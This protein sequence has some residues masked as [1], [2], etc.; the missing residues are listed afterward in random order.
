MTVDKPDLPGGG[1]AAGSEVR[2]EADSPDAVG[3]SVP[4]VGTES[5]SPIPASDAPRSSGGKHGSAS[6]RGWLHPA[7]SRSGRLLR[8]ALAALG[9]AVAF[10]VL[11]GL[12]IVVFAKSIGGTSSNDATPPPA[13]VIPTAAGSGTAGSA[14]PSDWVEQTSS[15]GVV[16]K[17]PPGWTPRSDGT[18]DFRVEPATSGP[19]INQVG[20]G[21]STATTDP[22]AAVRTYVTGTYS[23]QNS[24]L[25]Q[26]ATDQVS[27]RGERGRESTVSYSRSGTPVAVVVRGFPTPRG[28]LLLVTRA[29]LSDDGRAGKLASALDASIRLP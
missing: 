13:L 28:V 27:A 8:T 15:S 23:G 12:L 5:E 16:F 25:Q 17:A 26:P 19:G 2:S 4:T 11:L 21:L 3:G 10:A 9:I 22:D 6:G 20:V 7:Q 24:F 18:I 1:A 14:T 29:P